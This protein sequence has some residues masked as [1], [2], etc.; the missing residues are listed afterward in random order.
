MCH[1]PL[2]LRNAPQTWDMGWEEKDQKERKQFF[3][4]PCFYDF[5]DPRRMFRGSGC[6]FCLGDV[7]AQW[8]LVGQWPIPRASAS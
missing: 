8:L 1:C 2:L 7:E 3:H 6:V 5:N 4:R